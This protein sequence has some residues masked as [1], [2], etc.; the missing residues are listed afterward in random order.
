MDLILGHFADRNIE[1]L[2]SDELEIFEAILEIDDRDL[3]QWVTGEVAIP[4]EYKTD[5]FRRICA[6]R[7]SDTQC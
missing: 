3:I 6:Y 5:L 1:Q 7:Q 2:S 4:K